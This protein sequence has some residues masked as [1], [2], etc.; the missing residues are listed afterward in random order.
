VT[1]SLNAGVSLALYPSL[2]IGGVVLGTAV[3][4]ATMT[5]LEGFV[6]RRELGGL[7]VARTLRAAAVMV[8]GAA[9]LGLVARGVWLGLD[10][11]LGR[12][13]PA[14]LVSVGLALTLG[15]A[16][17]AAAMLRSGLPE[18]TQIRALIADRLSRRAS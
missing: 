9:V 6:L 13:L 4:G 1:L 17:Y 14:Q 18:A 5:L 11:L 2:G 3:A 8:L 16:A 12:S 15:V 10:A 7:E